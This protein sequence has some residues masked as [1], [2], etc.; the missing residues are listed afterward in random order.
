MSSIQGESL[1]D[2]AAPVLDASPSR[3]LRRRRSIHVGTAPTYITV[4]ALQLALSAGFGTTAWTVPQH[5]VVSLHRSSSDGSGWGAREHRRPVE[6]PR[7]HVT[8]SCEYGTSSGIMKQYEYRVWSYDMYRVAHQP[9]GSSSGNEH[10]NHCS[11][12]YV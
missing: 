11:V 9:T 5:G 2:M 10:T 3:I 6:H 8:K 12:S 7:L 1:L 4:L